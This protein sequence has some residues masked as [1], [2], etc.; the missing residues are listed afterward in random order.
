MAREIFVSTDV[1]TDGPI[2]GVYSMLSFGSVAFTAEKE[3][4]SAFSANLNTLAGAAQDKATMQWWKTQKTAWQAHRKDLWQAED[5]MK[6]Y[7]YWLKGLPGKPVFVGYPAAFDFMFICWYLI[8]FTGENP[9]SLNVI[10]VK[11]FAWCLLNKPF[12]EISKRKMPKKWFD[13]CDKRHVALDD[14]RE[15]GLLFCNM[16]KD[17]NE[18]E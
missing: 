2:P 11:T 14:A 15:Q 5:A 18:R 12:T 16:L 13:S 1:E 17:A 6:Q 7:L 3:I 8:K 10:D 4:I 9:F